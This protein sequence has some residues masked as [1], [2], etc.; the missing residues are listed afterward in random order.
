M[1]TKTQQVL[2]KRRWII[3][4]AWVIT[5]CSAATILIWAILSLVHEIN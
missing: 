1:L 3:F 5:A 2:A 4:A